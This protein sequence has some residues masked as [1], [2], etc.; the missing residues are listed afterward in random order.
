ML[1]HVLVCA[2]VCV[3]AICRYQAG[4]FLLPRSPPVE[5]PCEAHSPKQS[6]QNSWPQPP[7][8]TWDSLGSEGVWSGHFCQSSAIGNNKI[9]ISDDSAMTVMSHAE[10]TSNSTHVHSVSMALRI[11]SHLGADHM[12]A[13]LVLLNRLVA[14]TAKTLAKRTSCHS[15]PTKGAFCKMQCW[16]M[17]SCNYQEKRKNNC[18]WI[19]LDTQAHWTTSSSKCPATVTKIIKNLS[20]EHFGHFLVC[21]LIQLMFSDSALFFTFHWFTVL[22][23]AG[24]W[25]SSPQAQHHTKVQAQWISKLSLSLAG[26]GRRF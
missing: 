13:A 9:N 24:L 15:R 6:Q 26:M 20:L 10:Y 2:C 18:I 21:A 3:A 4:S 22:Q 16:V 17:L 5:V 19:H 1:Y 23:L 7:A 11:R 12:V 14:W 8:L 25:A